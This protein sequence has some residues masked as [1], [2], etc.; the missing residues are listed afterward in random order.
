MAKIKRVPRCYHCGMV[1]QS[2]NP[3]EK[4][5]V[6]PEVLN[7]EV[8]VQI[9]YCDACYHSLM[10]FN[11]SASAQVID[12][13]ILK[14]LDDAVASDALIIWVVDLF[15]FNGI[16][17]EKLAKKIKNNKVAVVGTKRDLFPKT[18]KDSVFIEFIGKRFEK[19]GI[20]PCNIKLVGSGDSSEYAQSAINAIHELRQGHDVFMIGNQ[21]SGKTSLI[22]KTLKFY[23]NKTKRIINIHLYPETDVNVLEIPLT[24]SAT[25]YELP[26]ISQTTSLVGM[27]EKDVYKMIVPKRE[28]EIKILA[29]TL[30]AGESL[31]VGSIASFEIKK[32]KSQTYKF[33]S[34][35]SVETKKVAA[36]NAQKTIIENYSSKAIRPVSNRFSTFRD[37][38]LYDVSLEN[39]GKM[40]DIN[41]E[42]L[43]WLSFIAKGQVIRVQSPKGV[44]V[45]EM[46]AKV[47]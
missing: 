12:D 46:L 26:G 41:I 14:I 28:R 4:G 35:E 15:S 10:E 23:V 29:K 17:N 5:Y 16:L 6:S 27:V 34:A 1:L 40:H 21:S 33:Y 38:E 22:N 7:R 24:R 43:G 39:D 13:E 19:Y 18:T 11:E 20:K 32:G 30:T 47:K 2:N 42:G 31:V 36:K 45:T 37:Y 44:A 9:I 8:P 3:N 25:F